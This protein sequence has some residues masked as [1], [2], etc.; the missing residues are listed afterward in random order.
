MIHLN[1]S[2]EALKLLSLTRT[3]DIDGY[4]GLTS[5]SSISR[6]LIEEMGAQKVAFHPE[7]QK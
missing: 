2:R 7:Q 3:V 1:I 5:T 4:R 6:K